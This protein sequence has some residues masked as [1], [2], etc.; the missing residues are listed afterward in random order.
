MISLQEIL[1]DRKLYKVSDNYSKELGIVSNSGYKNGWGPVP[2]W[3]DD[4]I[5]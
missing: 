2:M 4:C 3:L 5:G 1:W